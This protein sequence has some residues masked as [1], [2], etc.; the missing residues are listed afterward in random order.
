MI[1]NR[2]QKTI[3]INLNKFLIFN[4]VLR[5]QIV[6]MVKIRFLTELIKASKLSKIKIRSLNFMS[7]TVLGKRSLLDSIPQLKSNMTEEKEMLS[8]KNKIRM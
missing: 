3:R 4:Q 5:A 7:L 8:P 2:E 6:N 1:S